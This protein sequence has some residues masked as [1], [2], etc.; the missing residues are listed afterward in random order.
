MF[1][2]L[3]V[4]LVGLIL[5]CCGLTGCFFPNPHSPLHFQ[6]R[7]TPPSGLQPQA[8]DLVT[9]ARLT[10]DP[11]R[12]DPRTA[13]GYST[14]PTS[15]TRL[16]DRTPLPLAL[17]DV[18][19]MDLLNNRGI[20]IEADTVRIADYGVPVSKG[21]YDLLLT[22]DYRFT[23]TEVQS[24][25]APDFL[26]SRSR[27][28]QGDL[29]LSQLLPTGATVS[30]VYSATR[31]SRGN[32]A[33][34]GTMQLTQPLL[35][36]A[37]LAVTNAGIRIALLESQGTQADYR[38]TLE[39]QLQTALNTYWDLISAIQSLNVEVTSYASANE[40]LRVNRSKFDHGM[41]KI[42]DLYQTE[43]ALASR[44]DQIVT[45]RAAVRNQEDLL[46][47]QLF[48]DPVRPLWEA[49]ILPT[50]P[51]AWH[52]LRLDLDAVVA[53]A[54]ELRPELR[55]DQSAVG[56]ALERLKVTRSNVLPLLDFIARWIPN[57]VGPSLGGA[58]DNMED[59]HAN[60]Y[61]LGFQFSFPLQNRTARYQNK[62]ALAQLAIAREQ[63]ADMRDQVNLEVRQAV[64]DY[65]SARQ[66][67]DV[68]QSQIDSQAANLATE[69][70]REQV[71]LSTT[72]RVLSFQES[73]ASAQLQHVQ[74]VIA[75]NKAAI[76]VEHARGTLLESCG[77]KLV[78]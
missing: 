73:L 42:A 70:L 68:S 22:S 13:A 25:T 33:N 74:A 34:N 28:R 51:I 57:G 55:R 46:K 1:K 69:Q 40:L 35:Q 78:E 2:A 54:L 4:H 62:Q 37:G 26:P 16:Y 21:I 15:V 38:T 6:F 10:L 24:G 5:C 17:S 76:A 18:V 11:V 64:R 32:Y 59:G 65:E 19:T 14:L 53:Q 71:G 29:G 77:V 9:T 49:Q 66:Q 8:E 52:E 31:S 48:L 20:K 56:R 67:I 39:D 7:A 72:F 47:R 61:N 43:A 63:L 36:G 23:R 12:I 45:A 50:Q 3:A 60:T 58:Y 41:L 30:A 27:R 44:Y 75:T